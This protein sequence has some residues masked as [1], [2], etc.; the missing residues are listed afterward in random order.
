MRRFLVLVPLV[1][2]CGCATFSSLSPGTDA[3]KGVW[4]AKTTSILGY[5]LSDQEVLFC[6]PGAK[7]NCTKAEG[8]VKATKVQQ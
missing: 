3:S 1:L 6:S 4:V 8:D 7:P 2:A 5:Q